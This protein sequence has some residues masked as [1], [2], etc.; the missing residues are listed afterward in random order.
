MAA[1]YRLADDH[2][3]RV[4]D[5]RAA[6]GTSASTAAALGLS[7]ALGW[8]SHRPKFCPDLLELLAL[9]LVGTVKAGKLPLTPTKSKE[10]PAVRVQSIVAKTGCQFPK[11]GPGFRPGFGWYDGDDIGSHV[12]APPQ[13]QL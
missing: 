1:C 4:V 11:I 8:R 6:A 10:H 9:P 7:G 3:D 12:F 2:T 13:V 5:S